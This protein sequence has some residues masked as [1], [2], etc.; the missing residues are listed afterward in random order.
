MDFM[1]LL[2]YPCISTL[3]LYAFD[4]NTLIKQNW[5]NYLVQLLDIKPHL[6]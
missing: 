1:L 2:L 3:I 5:L 6:W 4:K